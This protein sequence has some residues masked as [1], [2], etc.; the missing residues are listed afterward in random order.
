MHG[1]MKCRRLYWN[2]IIFFEWIPKFL[3]LSQSWKRC[4]WEFNRARNNASV[5]SFHFMMQPA[6]LK[7][8]SPFS[9]AQHGHVPYVLRGAQAPAAGVSRRPSAL[10]PT[11]RDKSNFLCLEVYRFK[12]QA[13]VVPTT[14]LANYL[15]PGVIGGQIVHVTQTLLGMSPNCLCLT[16]PHQ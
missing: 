16:F 15:F 5:Q 11:E 9:G 6:R 4:I 10:K 2:G 1:R 7:S 3:V 8:I 12:F 14:I 13:F